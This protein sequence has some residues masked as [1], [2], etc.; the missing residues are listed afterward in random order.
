VQIT[1]VSLDTQTGP[2][3]WFS[4]AVYIDSVA[5]PSGDSR[6]SASCVHFTPGARTAWHRHPNGQTIYLLEGV[7]LCQRRGGSGQLFLMCIDESSS[8]CQ[9][10]AVKSCGLR[11]RRTWHFLRSQRGDPLPFLGSAPLPWRFPG[12]TRGHAR[13]LATQFFLQ[14]ESSEAS[15]MRREAS[16]V[17][18]LMCPFCVRG[19]L[20]VLTT[21]NVRRGHD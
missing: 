9:S 16:R 4:G 2:S 19:A 8:A 18:F 1:R 15:R 14:I 17:S 20:S 11:V 10:H 12:V 13:S 5:T 21:E 3:D 6:L 7:G